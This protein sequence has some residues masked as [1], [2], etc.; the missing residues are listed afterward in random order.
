[1]PEE[2]FIDSR[3]KRIRPPFS[4]LGAANTYDT[5]LALFDGVAITGKNL[6]FSARSEIEEYVS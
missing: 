2:T 3:P 5:A 6:Q 4:S 1:M